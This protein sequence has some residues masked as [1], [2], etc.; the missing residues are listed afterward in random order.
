MSIPHNE[1]KIHDRANKIMLSISENLEANIKNIEYLFKNCADVIKREVDIGAKMPLKIYAVYVDGLINRELIENVFLSRIIDYKNLGD[2][3]TPLT[4]TPTQ[5]I[6]DHFS[7]TFDISEMQSMDDMV[8]SILSGDTVIFVEGTNVGLKI[9][10]RGWPGRG[11]SAPETEAVIRGPR[12]GFVETIRFNTVLIRRRIRDTKLKVE[13]TSIGTRS[14]TDIAIM[15]MED[16]AEPNLVEDVKQRLQKYTIDGIF[17][18]GYVEQ[19]IEDSYKSPFPQT[20]AT[21]RPDKVAASLLEGKVAL[22]VDTS[23]FVILLPATLNCFFQA[24]EDYYQ[25]WEIMSFTRILRYIVSF[26]SF[27]L[28]G[29]Y[30]AILNFHPSMLP[31]T[32]VVSI[33]ASREGIAFLSVLEIIIMEMAFELLKEAGIR[34][35]GP[36]GHAIGVVGGIVIGQAAVDAKLISPMI[37]IIVALTAI[38]T[39]AI[40]DYSLTTAFRIIKYAFIFICALFGL[41]GFFIG[42]LIMF[43]HLASLESFG[44]PYLSPFIANDGRASDGLRDTILRYPLFMQNKRPRFARKSQKTRMRLKDATSTTQPVTPP[45]PV[46]PPDPAY[47]EEDQNKKS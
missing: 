44:T 13:M 46:Y 31:T 41:Y 38:A 45:G 23:P 3:D 7:A 19:M 14:R 6:M 5:L 22:V 30:I 47:K 32:I 37:V 39:F 43:A 27:A 10:S 25:R 36:V 17:D 1:D 8:R 40:P 2:E 26:L 16:I 24:A 35:P 34:L 9:A 42:L 11:I 20:Q 18:S 12:D 21:E 29:L 4:T 33:A 28:P 15:Y